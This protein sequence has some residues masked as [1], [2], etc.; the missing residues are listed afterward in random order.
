MFSFVMKIT[1]SRRLL[2]PLLVGLFIFPFPLLLSSQPLLVPEGT[3]CAE[4]GMIVDQNSKFASS[5]ITKDDRNLFF[6][7]I[8][9]MLFHFRAG[10]E[11]IKDV[12]V[13]DYDTG[14][15]I[16]GRKVFYV[17]NK[18]IATP[19]SWGIA[20]FTEESAAKK[21]GT[22]VDFDGAFTLLK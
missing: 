9:D 1:P 12:Y 3:K 19:M 7:D 18:K 22:P 17:L 8:G 2:I 16:D 4:C 14:E 10:R 21:W 13:R 20:A 15:R 6:C 11:K 5:V